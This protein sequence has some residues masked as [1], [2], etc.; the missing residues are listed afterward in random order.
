MNGSQILPIAFLLYTLAACIAS[1]GRARK[2]EMDKQV[3]VYA[4]SGAV[5]AKDVE[6][7][8]DR[9]AIPYARVNEFDVKAGGLEGCSVLIIPG[10]YTEKCA[11]GLGEGG[12]EQIRKFVKSGGGYIGICA[13]AYLAPER[14][15]VRG[16]PPGLGIIDIRNRR[17]AGMGIRTIEVVRPDH[18][19][20]RGYE[21]KVEIWYQNGPMIEAGEE[22]ETLAVYERGSAAV[23]CSAYGKGRV[24]IF[25]PHPEGSLDGEVDPQR[26]GTLKLLENAISFAK[27]E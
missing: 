27:S 25:S 15:E 5:L 19:V 10:G 11:I 14:V 18:P 21:G 4:G 17:E 16:H 2:H 20:A 8:L 23:V 12:F 3:C 13:G 22:V 24:I 26:I 6:T 7:A 1:P 9:L